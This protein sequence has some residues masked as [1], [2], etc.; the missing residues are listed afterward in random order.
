MG[1]QF[2]KLTKAEEE[3]MQHL[4]QIEEGTVR[5]ILARLPEPKPAVTTVSTIVRILEQKGFVSHKAY[6]R[7]HVYYPIISKETYSKKYIGTVI[8]SFF[9]QS[10]KT[11]VSFLAKNDKIDVGDLEEIMKELKKMS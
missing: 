8:D 5:D 10:P 6:G 2:Q 1:N 11:L 4:W 9:D 7:T 3:V